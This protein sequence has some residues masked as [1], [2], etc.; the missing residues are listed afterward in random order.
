MQ[1]QR[2]GLGKSH[3]GVFS[4]KKSTGVRR[5]VTKFLVHQFDLEDFLFECPSLGRF[6]FQKFV[7]HLIWRQFEGIVSFSITFSSV[8]T[9]QVLPWNSS[10]SSRRSHNR[11]VQMMATSAE[12]TANG[13][14]ARE[15]HQNVLYSGLDI[16]V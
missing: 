2:G 8:A 12:V 15:S 14:L 7:F 10:N 1:L 13:G 6:I 4:K 16:L 5:V 3:Q 9:S 11:S